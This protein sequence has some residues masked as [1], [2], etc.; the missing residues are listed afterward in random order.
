MEGSGSVALDEQGGQEYE[1][2]RSVGVQVRLE[3]QVGFEKQLGV[4]VQ[5]GVLVQPD[6]EV[7]LMGMLLVAAVQR[8]FLTMIQPAFQ[9]EGRG[10]GWMTLRIRRKK[11][12]QLHMVE[13][14]HSPELNR[15]LV[16]QQFT[17]PTTVRTVT[18]GVSSRNTPTAS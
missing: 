5:L 12:V 10:F 14:R 11:K 8:L 3:I 13:V 1:V 18:A 16:C 6:G 7:Q 15:L 4:E 17:Q 2:V 9:Q